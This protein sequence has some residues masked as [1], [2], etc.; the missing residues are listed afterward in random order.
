MREGCRCLQYCRLFEGSGDM[1]GEGT[2]NIVMW[3]V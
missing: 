1:E 3:P 2:G